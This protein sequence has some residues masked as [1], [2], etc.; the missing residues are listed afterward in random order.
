MILDAC[1]SSRVSSVWIACVGGERFVENWKVIK[2]KFGSSLIHSNAGTSLLRKGKDLFPPGHRLLVS[3]IVPFLS[4]ALI[5]KLTLSALLSDPPSRKE[6][7]GWDFAVLVRAFTAVRAFS[8]KCSRCR[9]WLIISGVIRKRFHVNV[10]QRLIVRAT[11][12][13]GISKPALRSLCAKLI[14]MADGDDEWKRMTVRR[15][16]IVWLKNQ[17]VGD[18]LFNFRTAARKEELVCTC[19]SFG[20]GFQRVGGHVC[21]RLNDVKDAPVCIRNNRNVVRPSRRDVVGRLRAQ[22]SS[23]FPDLGFKVPEVRRGDL[24]VCMNEVWR[25][26][27]GVCNEDE[28]IT[29]TKKVEGLVRTPIDHNPGDTLV[30]CPVKYSEGMRQLF[31]DN[32]GFVECD[33]S[34]ESLLAATRAAYL[35]R[36][37][38]RLARW[39]IR[40]RQQAI[41]LMRLPLDPL[42]SASR[43]STRIG[44]ERQGSGE[45]RWD[46]TRRREDGGDDGVVSEDGEVLLVEVQASECE[47]VNHGEEFHL[48]GGVIHLCG[49]ELLAS[50]G[51]GVFAG[52]SLGVSGGVFDG[53]GVGGVTRDSTAPMAKSEA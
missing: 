1:V 40:V 43:R 44:Q 32:D 42:S 26:D 4:R 18:L 27:L 24:A 52:W 46:K 15:M 6:L 39:D 53:G 33:E 48:V 23:S 49:K 3:A 41:V 2:R 25:G 10:R 22:I 16:R 36:N 7:M 30:C 14:M 31:L 21:F 19:E 34:E 37:F 38:D 12:D 35:E 28:V 29:W 17:S 51:D 8:E 11:Y 50:E 9:L 45:D 13:V 47:G 20:H 5:L